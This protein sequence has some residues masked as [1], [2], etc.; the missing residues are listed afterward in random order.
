MI[1]EGFRVER[2]RLIRNVKQLQTDLGLKEEELRRAK[3]V[4]EQL[5]MLVATGALNL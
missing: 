5:R 4:V 1:T 3:T 2:K